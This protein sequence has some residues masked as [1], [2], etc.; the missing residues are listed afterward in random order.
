MTSENRVLVVIITG[1]QRKKSKQTNPFYILLLLAG[2][3]FAV[4]ACAYGVMMV[5][6]KNAAT[7]AS[8]VAPE[9]RDP[10]NEFVDEHGA[11]IMLMELVLLG[12]GT[13][14]AIAYDEYTSSAES[15]E[16]PPRGGS[17]T[18]HTE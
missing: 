1:M 14:G 11:R 18:G 10:F 15:N 13:F 12:V 17:N 8:W 2:C 6:Q 16:E 9:Q 4:T 3:A 7:S 5:R